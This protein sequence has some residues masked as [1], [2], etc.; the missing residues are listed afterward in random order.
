MVFRHLKNE[1]FFVIS[2]NINILF[3]NEKQSIYFI[4]PV[5]V[6]SS[7]QNKSIIARGK[8]V[9]KYRNKVRE[10]K[11]AVPFTSLGGL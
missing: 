10:F 8:L 1:D 7:R 4:P 11:Y 3:P 9:D 6:R 5:S 2:K